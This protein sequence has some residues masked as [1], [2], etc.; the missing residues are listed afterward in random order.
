MKRRT[1]LLAGAVAAMLLPGADALAQQGYGFLR[2]DRL[3]EQIDLDAS[4]TLT[5][6]E[7][8]AAAAARFNALDLDGDG[9]VSLRERRESRDNRLRI[10]F[11][12]ADANRDGALDLDELEEVARQRARRRLLRLDAD[13]NGM[14]SLEE[15][16]AI[17]FPYTPGPVAGGATLTLPELD[18]RMMEMFRAA[19][20]DGDGIV[21]LREAMDGAGR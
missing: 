20:E 14:L 13:G 9:T 2:L 16:Q 4:G 15:L 3:F 1:C 10:R 11:D 8:R 7:M 12:R 6:Q 18:A 5:A 19:D 21:T 17:P